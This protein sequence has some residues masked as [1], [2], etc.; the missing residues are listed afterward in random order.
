MPVEAVLLLELGF[1]VRSVSDMIPVGGCGERGGRGG[2]DICDALCDEAGKDESNVL[3]GAAGAMGAA[4]PAI[5]LG[6]PVALVTLV[7]TGSVVWGDPIFRSTPFLSN[8]PGQA[9]KTAE[10][11]QLCS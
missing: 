5:P 1:D 7:R 8:T 10:S 6:Y 2:C 11:I 9:S 3:F 4:T